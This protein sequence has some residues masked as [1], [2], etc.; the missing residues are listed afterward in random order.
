MKKHSYALLS[1]RICSET[2]RSVGHNLSMAARRGAWKAH[3]GYLKEL[4]DTVDDVV[5]IVSSEWKANPPAPDDELQKLRAAFTSHEDLARVILSDSENMTTRQY[6]A[7]VSR[8]RKLTKAL[9]KKASEVLKMMR[10]EWPDRLTP[11]VL[12]RLKG[13]SRTR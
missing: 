1:L 6:E 5:Q 10:R 12:D 9:R 7:S 4:L 3:D 13:Y 8:F 11:E 2:I